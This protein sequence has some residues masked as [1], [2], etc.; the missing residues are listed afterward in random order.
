[1][2][3]LPDKLAKLRI[4][5]VHDDLVQNGGAEQ[6]FLALIELFP[7]A[8]IFTSMATKEWRE[9]LGERRLVT[10]FMQALPFKEKLYRAYFPFDPLA[11]ESFD[12]SGYDFVISHT[13]R[14][15][16]GVITKPETISISYVHNP[17]RMFWES[18]EYFGPDSR[19]KTFLSPL[20]SYFR[21]WDYT[22]AQ[23]VDHFIAN[24]KNI[25]RKVKRFFGRDSSVIY[26]FVDLE[27]FKPADSRPELGVRSLES[28][29]G[30]YFLVVTRLNR[31]K[32]VEIAIEAARRLGLHLKIVGTGPEMGKYKTEKYKVGRIEFL[33]SVSSE[34]LVR[35][36]KNCRAFI[37]TQ[38]E[39]FGIAALEAQASG[40]SVVAYGAGGA[41]ETVVAGKTGEFFSPQTTEALIGVLKDFKPEKYDPK[42]C[43]K[44]AERFSRE[45]FEKEFLKITSDVLQHHQ[46]YN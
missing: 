10:S 40:R 37:I 3:L 34:R 11:F 27:K 1:M 41:L 32:K 21:L 31:W 8:D 12:L 44:N 16:F 5:L 7:N 20:L 33:G 17:G 45:R 23:R 25:S 15:A 22:A 46:T 14:F 30:D 35:L 26:P 19:L 6:I 38:E 29:A 28:G 4:A 24:S 43:R 9:K 39:D 13:T 2:K 42:E 18:G 36:Y